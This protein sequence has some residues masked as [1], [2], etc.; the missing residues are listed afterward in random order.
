M[1][2]KPSRLA[3]AALALLFILIIG[4]VVDRMVI[5]RRNIATTR[6]TDQETVAMVHRLIR[7]GVIRNNEGE[8]AVD[9]L[10]LQGWERERVAPLL[11]SLH[12]NKSGKVLFDSRAVSVINTHPTVGMPLLR[13]R[14]LDAR[15]NVLAETTFNE[16]TW[17]TSR[18]Y[19]SGP[20]FFSIL[21]YDS[22]V[23]GKRHLEK[24]LDAYLSGALHEPVYQKTGDPFRKVA[25]GDDVRLTVDFAAQ[26][27]AHQLLGS[28]RGA[29]V[30]L[31]VKTFEII[32]AASTPSFSPND[33]GH[34]D[35]ERSSLDAD[36]R[37]FENRA[38]S[39]LYP[40]GSTFK[41]V[42]A[43]AWLESFPDGRIP[44]RVA[45]NGRKNRFGISCPH[46]HD[47]ISRLDEAFAVSCNQY[48]SEL[49][50]KVGPALV[51]YAE[52]FGFS[53]PLDLLEGIANVDQGFPVVASPAFMDGEGYPLDARFLDQNPRLLAQASFGQNM[54][55]A[56]PLQMALVAATI[57]N[58]GVS[59]RPSLVGSIST[60]AGKV[61]YRQQPKEFVKVIH[62]STASRLKL[63]M[64]S[65]MRNGTA[66]GVK[67][68]FFTKEKKYS[69][70]RTQD[71]TVP[72]VDVAG[73]TGTAETGDGKGA[74][75]W[76][77][78]F[79][80]AE[81][82]RYAVAVV[83]EHQGY[84]NLT[85]API[86]IDALAEALNVDRK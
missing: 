14:F 82:P 29:I 58:D 70:V 74:H 39:S 51:N 33:A 43:A 35:W 27:K 80:P 77:I 40:P 11:P 31:D 10:S 52:N 21:G 60:A 30:V 4:G 61:M 86:A 13:G 67:K 25:L 41:P 45:C 85:A 47:S 23:F 12:A 72:A 48:F 28:M 55:M 36:V 34:L 63:M 1:T 42:V 6:F 2:P 50:V 17:K 65:V 62:P 79:A 57:A 18:R 19:L 16:K 46:A 8:V 22:P 7:N 69:T 59:G 73:K 3:S 76:F 84:G 9:Y 56:T 44:V 53:K 15:G 32:I 54:V 64:I 75:S 20:E 5:H 68:I 38:F 66:K 71:Q 24:A 78:G 49:G 26:K 81:N 37:S 83:A